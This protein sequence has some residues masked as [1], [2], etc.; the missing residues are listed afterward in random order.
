LSLGDIMDLSKTNVLTGMIKD[1]L[2]KIARMKKDDLFY[3]N[4]FFEDNIKPAEEWYIC[5]KGLVLHYNV[6]EIACYANGEYDLTF[7]YKVLQ[8]RSLL[9]PEFALRIGLNK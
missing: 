6:Y 2:R 9:R 5:N 8:A 4:G 7:P 3:E 1:K